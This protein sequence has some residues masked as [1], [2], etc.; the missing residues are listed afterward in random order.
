MAVITCSRPTGTAGV[1]G[2]VT[3]I[4]SAAS[5]ASSSARSSAA[6][7]ASIAASSALRASLAARPTAPRSSGGELG[8][9]AQEVGQ[10]GLAPEVRDARGLERGRV[11]GRRDV[12]LRAARAARRSARSRPRHLVER[13]RRGHRRVERLRVDRDV[14]HRVA[15]RHH[16]GAAG[17]RARPRPPASPPRVLRARRAARPARATSATVR[18]GQVLDARRRAP[19]ARRRWRPSRPAPPWRRTGRRCPGP[20]ATL[21]GPE[22]ERRA[23]HRAD[24]ARDRRRP[25]APRTR[26]R[27]PRAP[28]AG[29]RRRARACPS[30]AARPASR[31]GATSTP[32]RSSSDGAQPAALGRLDQ[33]LALGDEL[34]RLVA[35]APAGELADLAEAVVVGAG[36]HAGRRNK[37]GARPIR[38][39]AR[40]G[41]CR[42]AVRPSTPRGRPRQIGGTCRRRARRCRPGPCGRSR[43]RPA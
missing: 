38:R 16:L 34:A 9:A 14:G 32:S 33:V 37:K 25:T 26:A 21:A 42:S 40:V 1:P 11:A 43:C 35:P 2:S 31:C 29:R 8:D 41:Q 13:D 36:D 23:Q 39:G 22:G 4:A 17:P 5:R 19:R 15:R 10:L 30:R 28:S 3:S 7:R 6:R 24:V 27:P 12:G 20:T 18:A